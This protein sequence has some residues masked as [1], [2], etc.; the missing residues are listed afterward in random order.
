MQS[1]PGRAPWS[2]HLDHLQALLGRYVHGGGQVMEA[3][4]GLERFTALESEV[5][6]ATFLDV[7]RRAIE[8][9]RSENVLQGQPG[10]SARGGVNVLAVSSLVGISFECVWILGATERA[11]PSPARQDPILLDPERKAIGERAGLRIALRG[12]RGS[13][14]ALQFTL[15]CEAAGQR[16]VVSYA[17]RATGENRPRASISFREVASQLESRR[18][19]AEEAPM[20]RRTDVERI[21]GDAIGAPVPGGRYAKEPAVIAGA[22]EVAVSA[23]ER[24]RRRSCRRG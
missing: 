3:L 7:V 9:L 11:F 21:A 14:E 24:D 12:A 5:E 20:L 8:T 18:V 16:L 4:R 17:R 10:A 13:E 6:H 2:E 15:A 23:A 1:H 22:A 19:S